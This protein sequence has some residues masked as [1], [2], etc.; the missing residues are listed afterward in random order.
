MKKLFYSFMTLACM[1]FAF[2]SC[3][4]VPM[5]YDD[6]RGNGSTEPT[7][8][9]TAAGSGT[10][11]DP[12]NVTAA[13]ELIAS[14]ADLTQKVY[15]KGVIASI[16]EVDASSYGN[17][18]YY[19]S[20]TGTS[21][22][23]LLV[24]RGYSLGGAKFTSEEEI[25]DGDT[26]IVY[27][28]LVNYNGT[29]EFT[30]GNYIYSLNGKTAG[31]GSE[32]TGTPSG[33][34]TASDPYNVAAAQ[35][36][37]AKLD[38]DV[39]SDEVYVKG[40]IVSVSEISTSYGNATYYISDDGTSTGQLTVYR[41]YALGN[42]KF[43]SETEIKAGDEVVICGQLV[44]FKGNTPEFTQGNY[45][46]S[47]NGKTAGGSS[48]TGTAKGTGTVSDP[49]N[50]AAAQNLIATLAADVKSDEV[51]VK[52]KIASIKEVS[53]SYGNAT[54]Y[55]SDDGTTNGQLTVFRGYALGNV[56]FT[57]ESEIKV[58]DEVVI[59][60]Q[61]VNYKGDTP[62]VAQ[63]NY[64]YSLNGSTTGG[65]SEGGAGTYSSPLDVNAAIA[66]GTADAAWVKGYIVG[67]VSGKSIADGATFNTTDGA[68]ATNILVAASASE[69]NYTKCMPVQLPKGDIRS[70]L[71]L[72]DNP[73]LLGKEVLLYGQLASYFSV[74][75]IK[76]VSYAEAEGKT[77]GTKP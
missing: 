40:K 19:I 7:V 11:E 25:Q 9:I 3:E 39:K 1:A 43:K 63:G 46:Y 26:V 27:G 29:Y 60:G 61:L 77:I 52:G 2:S 38:A 64:I 69:T 15:V 54:Y 21:Q 14:G 67:F 66:L 4:D 30:Q 74:P 65:S 68:V 36:L 75:G 57:S 31:G 58:G 73:S 34:G 22:N 41:G 50:V 13:N 32:T 51:Y 16:R 56:K 37:I 20:D 18:S 33:T 47:L 12:Y 5:P 45:I 35:A 28:Q 53:T 49:Y 8:E 48:D 24:Y 62:E 76:N 44:N 10:L 70:G 17:A 59:C 72:Q 71:N 42:E 23:Q 55:I 6:P